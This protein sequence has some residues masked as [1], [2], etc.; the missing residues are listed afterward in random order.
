MVSAGFPILVASQPGMLGSKPLR[1]ATVRQPEISDRLAVL[2]EQYGLVTGLAGR[3]HLW[4]YQ[5]HLFTSV[6]SQ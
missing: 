2:C 6:I 1:H 3:D 5:G 4:K